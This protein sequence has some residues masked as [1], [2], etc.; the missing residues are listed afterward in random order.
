MTDASLSFEQAGQHSQAPALEK[1]SRRRSL[2]FIG[3]A[4]A[5]LWGAIIAGA[6]AII[7]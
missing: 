6:A 4:S 7:P 1:W 5:G 2:L 3:T